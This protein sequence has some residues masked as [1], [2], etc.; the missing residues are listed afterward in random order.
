MEN[1]FNT[2]QLHCQKNTLGPNLKKIDRLI[3]NALEKRHLNTSALVMKMVQSNFNQVCQQ[4][5]EKFDKKDQPHIIRRQFSRDQA[6]SRW[7]HWKYVERIEDL[8]TEGYEGIPEYFKNTVTI[9]AFLRGCTEKWAA[10]VTL[11]KGP[12]TLEEAMQNIKSAIT[13]QTLIGGIKKDVKRV[14]L[15]EI[16]E[17]SPEK[18]SIRRT[19][20]RT[21]S[22]LLWSASVNK[23]ST[24]LV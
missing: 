1:L 23:G 6:K 18:R 9:H 12:K 17:S 8:A 7:D 11:D 21:P 20:F 14:T 19:N 16:D 24:R 13:N 4:M 10:L 5:K 3:Q 15:N 22:P 2:I